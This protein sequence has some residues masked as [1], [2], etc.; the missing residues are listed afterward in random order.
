[1]LTVDHVC[2]FGPPESLV[3]LKCTI[4]E[5]PVLIPVLLDLTTHD[6]RDSI[7]AEELTAREAKVK[8]VFQGNLITAGESFGLLLP[9]S[10]LITFVCLFCH[11]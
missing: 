4:S 9:G 11:I 3:S 2:N 5:G 8:G 7:R 6:P 1:M 10:V